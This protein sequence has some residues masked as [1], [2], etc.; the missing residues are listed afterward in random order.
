MFSEI[1]S[2]VDVCKRALVILIRALAVAYG[3]RVT[4]TRDS[5]DQVIKRAYSHNFK[6]DTPRQG[7]EHPGRN[8]AERI[9]NIEQRRE[10]SAKAKLQSARPPARPEKERDVFGGSLLCSLA[11]LPFR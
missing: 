3:F 1:P 7:R 9:G 4:V 5:T 8:S 10:P 2:T 6:E 11:A